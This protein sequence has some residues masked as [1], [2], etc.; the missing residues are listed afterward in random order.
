MMEL[1]VPNGCREFWQK[2]LTV[3]LV[4]PSGLVHVGMKAMGTKIESVKGRD[5]KE[6]SN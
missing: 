2:D 1:R 4:G 5:E 6:E 3:K